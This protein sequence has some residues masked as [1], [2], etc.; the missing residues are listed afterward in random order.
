ME[1]DTFPSLNV[2]RHSQVR[3]SQTRMVPSEDAERH[4]LPSSVK[5]TE[6]T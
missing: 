2:S 3:S 6:L 4:L 5:H 1:D